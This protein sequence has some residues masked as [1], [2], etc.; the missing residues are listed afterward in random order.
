MTT[1]Q[2]NQESNRE[3]AAIL[4]DIKRPAT[5]SLV[6]MNDINKGMVIRSNE[7]DIATSKLNHAMSRLQINVS[8]LELLAE[9]HSNIFI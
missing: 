2:Q 3:L 7:L 6:P 8:K 5:L 1:F 9:G 4:F